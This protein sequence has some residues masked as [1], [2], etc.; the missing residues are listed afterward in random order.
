MEE[1]DTDEAD[2][3]GADA[4][5][6]EVGHRL[7]GQIG[8][9]QHRALGPARGAGGV[10]DQ[11][12]RIIGHIRCPGRVARLVHQILVGQQAVRTG[13]TGDDDAAQ[14]RREVSDAGGHRSQNRFGDHQPCLTVVDQE[15]DLGRGQPEVDRNRD[16]PD[17]VRRQHRLDELGAVQ[18]QDHH[19]VARADPSAAQGSGQCRDPVAKVGPGDAVAQKSQRSG[20]RLHVCVPFELIDPVLSARQIRLL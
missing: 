17:H 13:V 7:T 19:P 3:V 12:R 8:V 4:V 16:G 5:R 10:H 15:G 1:R 18:H 2:V 9:G 6:V 11:R 20:A 14:H